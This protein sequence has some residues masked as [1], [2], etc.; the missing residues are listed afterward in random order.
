MQVDLECFKS[1][2]KGQIEQRLNQKVTPM[3]NTMDTH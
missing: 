3:N 2:K 1:N